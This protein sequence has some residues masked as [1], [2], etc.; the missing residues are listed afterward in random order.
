M[1][2]GLDAVVIGAGPAGLAAARHI[3]LSGLSVVCLERLA[4]GGEINN[5]GTLR[6]HAPLMH[7]PVQAAVQG[8]DLAA[9]LLDA[10]TEAGAELVLAGVA[11]LREGP[12]WQVETGEET[13]EAP[14]IVLATGLA[15]GRIG[16]PEEAG[17]AGRGLSHCASCDGPLY[18]GQPVVVIG[19]DRWALQ[20]AQDLARVA[21]RVTLIA[22]G[23]DRAPEGV[24]LR[25][26]RVVRLL[27]ADGLEAVAIEQDGTRV[28]LPARAAFVYAN[29]RPA[30]PGR[31]PFARDGAGRLV[32]D[33]GLQ[34]SLAGAYAAGDIR[35]GA[36]ERVADAIADGER[37]ARSVVRRL[38]AERM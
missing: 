32:I 36:P 25:P 30:L 18:A 1:S 31:A 21:G 15:P 6:D 17:F 34:T 5:L 7:G 35:A 33:G 24:A 13:Y 19:A 10:A 38:R 12:R 9:A 20:E 3:A 26:G 2:R 16:L 29:R 23:L 22:E 4:P 11:G 8:P 37:A 27:G 14:A 28:E